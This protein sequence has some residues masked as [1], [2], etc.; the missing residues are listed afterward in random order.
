ML[1]GIY[2]LLYKYG[3]ASDYDNCIITY[4]LHFKFE[5]FHAW[6]NLFGER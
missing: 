3:C 6:K 2:Q 5:V 1:I 4:N